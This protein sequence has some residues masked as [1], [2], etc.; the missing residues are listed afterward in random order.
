MAVAMAVISVIFGTPALAY[1]AWCVWC[2]IDD[3]QTRA[4][5]AV[6]VD[7]TLERVQARLRAAKAGGGP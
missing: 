7:D 3:Q 6:R 1:T 4:L 2:V 5:R